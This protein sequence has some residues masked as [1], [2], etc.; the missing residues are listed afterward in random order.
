M[1]DGN[2][3]AMHVKGKFYGIMLHYFYNICTACTLVME[4]YYTIYYTIVDIQMLLVK[5]IQL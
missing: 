5:I 3:Y 4:N 2:Y 1:F